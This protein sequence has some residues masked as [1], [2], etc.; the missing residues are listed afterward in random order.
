MTLGGRGQRPA[1]S[2]R[3][4]F[5]GSICLTLIALCA[6]VFPS[7]RRHPDKNPENRAAAEEKFKEIS[8]AYEVLSD[9]EKRKTY[10][11]YG[12]AGLKEGQSN[13]GH[14][15]GGGAANG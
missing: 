3:S 9:D 4:A 15:S 8:E 6:R 5:V 11:E 10:D 1:R 12:E 7:V 2:R 13:C 14:C